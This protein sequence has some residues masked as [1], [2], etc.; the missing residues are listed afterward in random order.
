MYVGYLRV[1]VT[2]LS[3]SWYFNLPMVA[4]CTRTPIAWNCYFKKRIIIGQSHSP[5]RVAD[6]M[7]YQL[8]KKD[9]FW[10][11]LH[12]YTD[13]YSMFLPVLVEHYLY[14]AV[15]GSKGDV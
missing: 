5:L 11:R 8:F 7:K 15:D 2:K 3:T 6:E 14:Q 10:R 4:Y 12:S 1:I 9:P 13:G